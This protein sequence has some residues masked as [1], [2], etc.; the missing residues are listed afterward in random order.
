MD[1][2]SSEF[3][4]IILGIISLIALYLI[5]RVAV[6][7]GIDDSREIQILKS[8]LRELNSRLREI[9]KKN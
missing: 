4:K 9:E 1:V 2:F 7:Q 6:K 3:F 8:E 5:I